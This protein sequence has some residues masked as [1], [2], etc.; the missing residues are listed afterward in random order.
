MGRYYKLGNYKASAE[1]EMTIGGTEKPD[2]T[3]TEIKTENTDTTKNSSY[4]SGWSFKNYYYTYD[5]YGSYT[6]SQEYT[7][8]HMRSEVPI[9]VYDDARMYSL[10]G[11][12]LHPET[13][14][15]ESYPY[16]ATGCYSMSFYRDKTGA[17]GNWSGYYPYIDNAVL[18]DTL[19]P[20]T[21]M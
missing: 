1:T 6:G 20:I 7:A 17:S 21:K 4:R 19:P 2:G 8:R 15:K 18:E 11:V 9:T 12:N 14:R 3:K 13:D 16:G 10:K 5:W